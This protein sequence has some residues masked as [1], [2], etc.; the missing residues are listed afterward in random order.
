MGSG[1][2]LRAQPK[3]KTEKVGANVHKTFSVQKMLKA[4]RK[5]R[6]F[7]AFIV[8]FSLIYAEISVENLT[9]PSSSEER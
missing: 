9:S 3:N 4:R 5:L 8:F 1:C 2:G 7:F 6:A